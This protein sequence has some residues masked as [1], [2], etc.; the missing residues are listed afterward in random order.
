MS[1]ERLKEL[2][3]RKF[4]SQEELAKASG[5]SRVAIAN[6]ERGTTKTIMVKT[7]IALATA[8]ECSVETLME[9]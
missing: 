6:I 5:V 4:M 2:R 3:K 1:G 9:D 8:L 7:L